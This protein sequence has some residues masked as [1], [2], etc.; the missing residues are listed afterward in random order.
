MHRTPNSFPLLA[1]TLWVNKNRVHAW[2]NGYHLS[3]NLVILKIHNN[4]GEFRSRP[5]SAC[6]D[7]FA[8]SQ[9]EC[10]IGYCTCT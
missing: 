3:D 5:I 2:F 8:L 7:N 9:S 6:V 4:K 1:E 10:V